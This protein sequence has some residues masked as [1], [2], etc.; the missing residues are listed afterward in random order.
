MITSR[1]PADANS[2]PPA[3][4]RLDS[5][6][7]IAS[8]L[9]KGVRTVQRWERTESLP[10]RRHGQDR[11]SSVFAYKSELDKWWQQQGIPAAPQSE[12]VAS[13][14]PA[15]FRVNWRL[16]A[17][18]SSIAVAA[19]AAILWKIWPS[20]ATVYHP[21]PLTAEHGWETQPSFSPDARRIAYVWMPPGGHPSIYIKSIGSDSHVRL[22]TGDQPE[23]SP[24]W[25]PDGRFIAFLRRVHP[26]RPLALMLIPSSGGPESKISENTES[27]LSWSADG[28]WLLARDGPP[29]MRSIVAISVANGAKHVLTGP[30][31]FG[32][33]GAGL[34]PD[35]RRL[36]FS[37]GGPGPS[38]VY[39][40]TLGPGLSPQGEPR[41][42]V[43][44]LWVR[45]LL[46]TPDGKELIYTDGTPEEGVGLWRL[47][48]SHGARP[49]T[50]TPHLPSHATA[51]ALRSS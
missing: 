18:V 24:A 44:N 26:D 46:V 14:E 38:T 28:Q 35:S 16:P 47:R 10:I 41:P 3:D 32:S 21:I 4:D 12:S 9:K 37:R 1:M 31:E 6:K 48:L 20:A 40:L 8:Y 50:S 42:L 7:E 15:T 33:N 49:W 34:S 43:P 29:R 17:L 11:P 2:A 45:E 51:A 36:I 39:E 19:A 30:F 22:T 23:S 25:S 27:G 13:A 5:W